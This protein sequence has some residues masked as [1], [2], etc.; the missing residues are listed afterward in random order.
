MVTIHLSPASFALPA[1]PFDVLEKVLSGREWSTYSLGLR[2]REG[3][4]KVPLLELVRRS[5]ARH[6]LFASKTLSFELP[7]VDIQLD[8]REHQVAFQFFPAVVVGRY[9]KLR[10]DIAQTRHYCYECK[11]SGRLSGAICPTCN[12][13]QVL[14]KE[15]VQELLAPFFKDV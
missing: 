3:V 7:D 11:G 2:V 6:P 5:A 8:A 15:S 1:V 9:T 4:D 13:E 12:G 14:T 10:R